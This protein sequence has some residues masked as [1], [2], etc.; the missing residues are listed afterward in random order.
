MCHMCYI[1]LRLAHELLRMKA[2]HESCANGNGPS[3]HT[4]VS[5]HVQAQA[6]KRCL[7]SGGRSD[8]HSSSCQ[9]SFW[10][11]SDK[12]RRLLAVS[13]KQDR[14]LYLCSYLL[15]NLSEDPDIERKMQK[16]VASLN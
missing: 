11:G 12:E 8:A 7:A 14:L 3:K 1:L 15:L 16:K 4:C 13:Q 2:S 5:Y 9:G 10:D 6:I